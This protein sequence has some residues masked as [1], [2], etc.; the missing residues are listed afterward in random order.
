M[1]RAISPT[2]RAEKGGAPL[3]RIVPKRPTG[4]GVTGRLSRASRALGIEHDR[5][6]ADVGRGKALLAERDPQRAAGGDDL[7]GDHRIARP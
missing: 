2:W 1:N 3:T 6:L 5:L 4:P 7:F